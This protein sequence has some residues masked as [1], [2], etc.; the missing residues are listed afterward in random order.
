MA[1]SYCVSENVRVKNSRYWCEDPTG[2]IG[3][4][5][6]AFGAHLEKEA[7]TPGFPLYVKLSKPGRPCLER[8][9]G[10]DCVKRGTTD[11][12]KSGNMCEM[13]VSPNTLFSECGPALKPPDEGKSVHG[14]PVVQ[15][16]TLTTSSTE[17]GPAILP[18]PAMS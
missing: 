16:D 13:H 6:T 9:E 11:Y 15:M 5:T 1:S 10:G 7:V 8:D 18:I 3:G 4:H 2:V 12:Y 14:R 17:V